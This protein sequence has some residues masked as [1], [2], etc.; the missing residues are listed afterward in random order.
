MNHQQVN[1]V[2]TRFESTTEAIRGIETKV[3]RVDGYIMTA[4]KQN[5]EM[6]HQVERATG[7]MDNLNDRFLT[8]SDETM[9]YVTRS[10][11]SFA[12]IF[13]DFEVCVSKLGI[14][15]MPKELQSE[16]GP[17]LVPV[18]V[19]VLIVTVSNCIFGFMLA[20][21]AD[22][23]G[24]FQFFKPQTMNTATEVAPS[25]ED[26][27]LSTL[28]EDDEDTMNILQLFAIFH[29]ALIGVAIVYIVGEVCRHICRHWHRVKKEVLEL[30][31]ELEQEED[32][33]Q[34]WSDPVQYAA[35]YYDRIVTALG[36]QPSDDDI[37][38]T[39][40][41]EEMTFYQVINSEKD[42]LRGMFP[43]KLRLRWRKCQD[44]GSDADG[45]DADA[46]SVCSSREGGSST[47]PDGVGANLDPLSPLELPKSEASVG[48]AANSPQDK[49]SVGSAANSP[50]DSRETSRAPTW[51]GSLEA[52]QFNSE[53]KDFNSER[54]QGG[55]KPQ[56]RK[57]ERSKFER[58]I[59]N[60]LRRAK[61][62]TELARRAGS[63]LPR[64]SSALFSRKKTPGEPG[65]P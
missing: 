2:L 35:D 38:Q 17:L 58:P 30:L 16:L 31:V 56:S 55:S 51:T 37:L 54:T 28:Q 12:D 3:A 34:E 15:D 32:F 9:C 19:L 44:Q 21:D 25:G 41:G 39:G 23:Q 8:K 11:D 49:A 26:V 4:K 64:S 48:L 36:R 62:G 60:M 53:R 50:Q 61:Q 59:S 6:T 20:N 46:R 43:I 47:A 65:S 52:N 63:V 33:E 29:M 42:V 40:S 5:E 18:L 27:P 45:G 13:E 22:L 57:V 24:A 14:L 10:L 7:I 1:E